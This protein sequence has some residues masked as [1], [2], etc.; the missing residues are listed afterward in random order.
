MDLPLPGAKAEW[1]EVVE[2]RS[3]DTVNMLAVKYN[4]L[5]GMW[6][7]HIST[8]LVDEVWQRL[9]LALHRGDLSP[10]VCSAKVSPRSPPTDD[11]IHLLCVYNENYQDTDQVMRVES[12]LRRCVGL[13]GDLRYKPDIF[14]IIGIYRNNVWGFRPSIYI[15]QE[16]WREKESKIIVTG[17]GTSYQSL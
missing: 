12:L 4:T 8:E 5:D 3:M 17:T 1:E 10:H 6:M 11:R 13:T 15:S 7:S 9:C 2:E 16:T 14:T